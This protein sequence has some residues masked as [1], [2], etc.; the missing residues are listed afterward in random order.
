MALFYH[1][2]TP[3]NY[4]ICPDTCATATVRGYESVKNA[5]V[6]E[7]AQAHYRTASFS[8]TFLLA[9]PEQAD[10]PKRGIFKVKVYCLWFGHRL[11]SNKPITL[12]VDAAGA[13]V[14][15]GY[16]GKVVG[17]LAR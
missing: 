12:T 15:R 2:A 11:P 3:W 5:T 17:N 7:V 9:D 6:I 13:V 10:L 1:S 8:G 14:M 16:T 4:D